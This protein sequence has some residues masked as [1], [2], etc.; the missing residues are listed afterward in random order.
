MASRYGRVRK[1]INCEFGLPEK[2]LSENYKRDTKKKDE[3][4][5]IIKV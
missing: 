3:C 2:N 4:K 1:I 5:C